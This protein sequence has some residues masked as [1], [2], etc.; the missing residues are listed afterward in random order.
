MNKKG[1]TLIEILVVVAIIGFL[2]ASAM[3]AINRARMKG[4]DARRLADI[5]QIQKALALYYDKNKTYP[6]ANGWQSDC[7]GATAFKTALQPL[8]TD[9]IMKSIPNDPLSPNNPILQCYFYASANVSPPCP[10]IDNNLGYIIA[11]QTETKL[12]TNYKE[13]AGNPN[14]YCVVP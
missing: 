1:Y 10:G 14:F 13:W 7:S 2:A 3:Y 12:T 6:P 11:F 5:N 9:G 4:R 8:V